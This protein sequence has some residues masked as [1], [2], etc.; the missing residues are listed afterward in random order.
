MKIPNIRI[1]ITAILKQ[2]SNSVL[3]IFNL[4]R[5]IFIIWMRYKP[6][7]LLSF[8]RLMLQFFKFFLIPN[9]LSTQTALKTVISIY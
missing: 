3:H 4:E 1:I 6:S 7:A 9:L 2:I 5:E 8:A